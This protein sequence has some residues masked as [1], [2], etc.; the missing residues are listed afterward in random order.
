[1]LVVVLL[2]LLVLTLL[3]LDQQRVLCAQLVVILLRELPRAHNALR[4]PTH[5]QRVPFR[6]L[7]ALPIHFL[8][9]QVRHH[10]LRVLMVILQ[11]VPH[12]A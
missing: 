1:M 6:V 3:R 4:V 10:A 7:S 5:H 8:H 12:H 9:Q 11:R 2:V